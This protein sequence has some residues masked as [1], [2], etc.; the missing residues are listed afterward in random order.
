MTTKKKKN[1]PELSSSQVLKILGLRT[2]KSLQI[3]LKNGELI[4]YVFDP[5]NEEWVEKVYGKRDKR[6][7]W[8]YYRAHV[9][10]YLLEHAIVSDTPPRDDATLYTPEILAIAENLANG[11]DI[12]RMAVFSAMRDR[13]RDIGMRRMYN[14]VRTVLNNRY[15]IRPYKQAR[16]RRV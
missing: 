7:R 14:L 9:D 2:F 1:G 3:K 4:P 16:K 12:P 10:A 11:D 8:F 15:G 5:V 6:P 13:H